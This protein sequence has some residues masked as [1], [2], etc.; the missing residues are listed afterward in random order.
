MSKK[1]KTYNFHTEWEEEFFVITFKDK[2][3]CLICNIS[4]SI[5]KKGNIHRHSTTTH[6]NFC[7][8]PLG[9]E[10]RKKKLNDLKSRLKQQPV[11]TIWKKLMLQI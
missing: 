7:D 6:K 10:I 4:M 2:C 1:P 9:S 3:V 8:A 11:F 5:P